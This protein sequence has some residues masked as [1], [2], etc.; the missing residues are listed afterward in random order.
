MEKWESNSLKWIH[1]IRDQSYQET[2]GMD[3]RKVA[4]MT[5]KRAH[6]FIKKIK[7]NTKRPVH[8]SI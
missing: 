7:L 1:K 4:E 2:K 8:S 3:L 6:E 5:N